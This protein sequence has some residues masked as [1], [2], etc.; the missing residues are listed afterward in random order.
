MLTATFGKRLRYWR[1]KRGLSQPHL[2]DKTGVAVELLSR[3]ENGRNFPT[4]KTVEI[5]LNALNVSIT[6]FYSEEINHG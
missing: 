2:R 5:L 6:E 1:E 4:L 3:Y